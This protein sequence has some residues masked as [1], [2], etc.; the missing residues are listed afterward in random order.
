MELTDAQKAELAAAAAR[1]DPARRSQIRYAFPQDDAGKPQF[2]VYDDLGLGAGGKTGH[3]NEYIVF[4][5]L[6]RNDGSHY[7]PQQNALIAAIPSPPERDGSIV[8]H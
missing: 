7:D 4:A 8:V 1:V 2:V 6:N 5:V 3:K